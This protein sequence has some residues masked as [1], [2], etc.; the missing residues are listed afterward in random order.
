MSRRF[1]WALCLHIALLVGC[2]SN[3]GAPL[4]YGSWW[5]DVLTHFRFYWIPTFFAL[6]VFLFLAR[7][8]VSAALALV[9]MGYCVWSI[10]WYEFGT[11]TGI[12]KSDDAIRVIAYN[13][14]GKYADSVEVGKYLKKMDPDVLLVIE[15]QKGWSKGIS[16]ISKQYKHQLTEFRPGA[17]GIWLLSKF[18]IVSFDANLMGAN[19]RY[20]TV[21]GPPIRCRW[22]G[23]CAR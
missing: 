3:L 20:P 2:L 19:A 12:A 10:V 17:Q 1:L 6:G 7:M 5:A 8:R 4:L 13:T 16:E 11:E 9:V 14:R 18:P 15:A 23:R 22:Q 21:W